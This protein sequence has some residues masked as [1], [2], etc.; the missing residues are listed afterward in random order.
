MG[1]LGQVEP[2]QDGK[3]RGIQ[4]PSRPIR[5]TEPQPRQTT[6]QVPLGHELA[7]LVG[8]PRCALL[9]CAQLRLQCLGRDAVAGTGEQETR[10]EPIAQGRAGAFK[11]GAGAGT[12][13]DA[14]RL[15]R[16]GSTPAESCGNA[17]SLTAAAGGPAS[18]LE[19]CEPIQTAGAVKVLPVEI[20]AGIGVALRS[21]W[22]GP[23]PKGCIPSPK[24]QSR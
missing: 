3:S 2:R 12:H 8:H 9:C 23:I 5:T 20:E 13:V 18:G 6:P 24:G 15:P 7:N 1:S 11:G 10:A 22:S 4:P 16:V 14:I 19:G 17:G 21:G